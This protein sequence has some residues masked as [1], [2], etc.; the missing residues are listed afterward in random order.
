MILIK[1]LAKLFIFILCV[2]LIASCSTP[3]KDK[4]EYYQSAIEYIEK[5][6]REAAILQLLNALQIDAKYGDAYYQLGLLYLEEKQPKKA[7]DSLLRAADL[8]PDNL[9]ASL[10]VAQF[11]MFNRKTEEGRQRIEHILERDPDH[12]A[13]LTLLANIELIEGKYTASIE[14]LEKIGPAVDTSD[15]LQNVKGRIFAAQEQWV[16]AEEAFQKAIDLDK[17]NL[18][19][20]RTLLLLYQKKQEQEKAKGLLDKMVT[21]FPDNPFVHQLLA[22]YYRRIDD[23]ELLL[24]ELL[25]II[26]FAPNNPRFRLQLSEFYRENNQEDEA[27]TTLSEARLTDAGNADI[28]AALTTLYFDQKRY[29]EAKTL[30]DELEKTH[31]GHGGVKLIRSRFLLNDGKI[32]DGI[33][34]LQG[35]NK[36]FPEWG[37]PYF[38]LGLAHYDLGEVDLAQNAVAVAIQKYGRSAK[39]HTLMAQIFQVQGAFEDAQKEA[40]TALR[41]N[42]KNIRSALILSRALIDLKRYEQAITL[43]NNMISQVAGNVEVLGNLAMAYLG[44]EEY[45]EAEKFL[46]RLIDLHPGNT[47]AVLLLLDVKFKNK[48]VEGEQFVEQQILKAPENARLYLLLGELLIKQEKYEEALSVYKNL[49][50]QQPEYANAY[51][52]EANLL[53]KLNRNDDALARYT[54]VLDKQPRLLSAHMAIADLL[55]L[56]RNDKKAMEHYREVLKIE[57]NYP[58]AANNLAWLIAS[59]PGGDLGEAL[60][61]AMRAKQASPDSPVIA[62]TLGW[63]HLKRQ[64]YSLAITQFELALEKLPGNPTMAYHLALALRGNSQS[65]KAEE[66]LK[67][68]IKENADFPDRENAEKLLEE[69]I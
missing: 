66:I 40:V 58:P 54:L 26:E 46:I 34:L 60:M 18:S 31:P 42:P 56:N 62:D 38:F 21:Q 29:S 8:E 32:R 57:E 48:L 19:N 13:A 63:V 24:Q 12:L 39:Y 11:Y 55:Q 51:M 9:D 52:V 25:K 16:Q 28:A 17:G 22:N 69:L 2:N 1:K 36:D 35:L 50:D 68:L 61:F 59:E 64:S 30:L 44:K 33:T 7:F 5:N 49:Q 10:R 14:A 3:D 67:Q 15:E 4:V 45:K 23:R 53:R 20:Y 65:Q 47:Q 41:L 37:E 6:E 43:L 27:E